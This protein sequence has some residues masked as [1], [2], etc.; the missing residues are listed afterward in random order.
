MQPTTTV[1][2]VIISVANAAAVAIAAAAQTDTH[3]M[4][5]C[6]TCDPQK[7]KNSNTEN[8][9]L[10]RAGRVRALVISRAGSCGLSL[11]ADK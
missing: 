5:A 6:D 10:F 8:I 1:V 7:R 11:H 3:D 9:E 4:I 2:A